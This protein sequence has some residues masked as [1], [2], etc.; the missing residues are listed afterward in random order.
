MLDAILKFLGLRPRRISTDPEPSTPVERHVRRARERAERMGG[1]FPPR[2]DGSTAASRAVDRANERAVREGREPP[3]SP[4]RNRPDL[5]KGPEKASAK[6][7]EP[8]P[9]AVLRVRVDVSRNR[10]S[11]MEGLD[12]AGVVVCGPWDAVTRAHPELAARL[13]NRSRDPLLPG[14]HTPF[15]E[16][17]VVDLLPA[18]RDEAGLALFGPAPAL[19][20]RP[21]SGDAAVA[22]S[23]GRTSLLLHGGQ[24]DAP[25]DGS[26]R[27]PDAAMAEILG[28]VP[29]NPASM[30]PRLRV[31]VERDPAT[32][33]VDDMPGSAVADDDDWSSYPYPGSDGAFPWWLWY[34]QMYLWDDR[35]DTARDGSWD[36]GDP[37]RDLGGDAP[38]AAAPDAAQDRAAAEGLSA[39]GYGVIPEEISPPQPTL[40]ETFRAVEGVPS[41]APEPAYE[42]PRQP[43]PAAPATSADT[44][45]EPAGGAYGR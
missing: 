45:W 41:P 32:V 33:L 10:R 7:P 30:K 37:V 44:S 19:R 22:D 21:V 26:I 9:L 5:S 4:S 13:G 17:E 28:R 6:A 24:P 15:G 31:A 1:S 18:R 23:N 34:Q 20:L 36:W 39:L 38:S 14:G 43:E 11:V 16:Y 8:G 12:A 25:T 40:P 2:P 3:F 27:V 35:D 29:G 42:A